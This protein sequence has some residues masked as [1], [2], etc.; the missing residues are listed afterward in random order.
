MNS[1][2]DAPASCPRTKEICCDR[3]GSREQPTSSCS[4]P[5]SPAWR[6]HEPTIASS[7]AKKPRIPARR[8][9]S[10]VSATRDSPSIGTETLMAASYGIITG[11]DNSVTT[12]I[13][14][15]HI[16]LERFDRQSEHVA[17]AALGLNYARC[18]GIGLQLAPQP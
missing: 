6:A 9:W 5:R 10:G 1:A 3:L 12:V 18:T 8:H 14:G 17:D 4:S 16:F 15:R 11:A 2:L 13:L 7:R